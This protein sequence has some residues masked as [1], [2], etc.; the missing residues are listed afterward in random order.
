MVRIESP[1]LDDRM[2][3]LKVVVAIPYVNAFGGGILEDEIADITQA[4]A[5]S[6]T[7]TFI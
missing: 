6:S 7:I 4:L 1:R 5:I 3:P 2:L